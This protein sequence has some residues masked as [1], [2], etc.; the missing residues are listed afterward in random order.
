M[1]SQEHIDK[2]MNINEEVLLEMARVGYLN[3]KYEIVIWTDDPGNI[4][5]MHIWDRTTRG[6]KFHCCVC[7]NKAEYF[8]HTGKE[9]KLNTKLK[10]SL[11]EFLQL[12][13][14]KTG[15]SNWQQVVLLWNMN[16]SSTE[17]D[18]DAEMPDYTKLK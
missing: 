16:N 2:A 11:V 5:H 6:E 3:D 1:K 12:P 8:S 17:I 4:P 13:F 9:D 10:K 15:M 14:R 18:D 7:L